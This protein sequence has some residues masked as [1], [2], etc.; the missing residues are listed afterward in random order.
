MRVK[1]Q[2]RFVTGAAIVVAAAVVPG[3]LIALLVIG[4]VRRW[5]GKVRARALVAGAEGHTQRDEG[6]VAGLF[7]QA[8]SQLA[9]VEG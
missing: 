8:D 1:I 3:G 7:E 9:C 6:D 4:V 2:W 5:R